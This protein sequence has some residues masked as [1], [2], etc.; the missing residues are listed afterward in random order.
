L[1]KPNPIL[2]IRMNNMLKEFKEL[3][4]DNTLFKVQNQTLEDKNIE[5]KEWW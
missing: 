2:P 5:W 3:L 4:L 1:N